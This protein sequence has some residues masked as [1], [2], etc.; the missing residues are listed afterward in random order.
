MDMIIYGN[1]VYINARDL[2]SNFPN[3]A[4]YDNWLRMLCRKFDPIPGGEYIESQGQIYFSPAYTGMVLSMYTE[5]IPEK[6]R[7]IRGDIAHATEQLYSILNKSASK[8]KSND[9]TNYE[10]NRI[11]IYDYI[12][13]HKELSKTQISR[14][15]SF[16]AIRQRR[17]IID[18]LISVEL[19]T[20]S[21]I[22]LKDRKKSTTYYF[23]N[24]EGD[25]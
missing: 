9:K 8:S 10:T 4:V 13:Q 11:K 19:I 25:E 16:I 22:K 2:H 21:N 12:K 18:D 5:E 15:F 1:M 23:F 7:T 24:A 3:E 17:A 6:L 20:E 14:K